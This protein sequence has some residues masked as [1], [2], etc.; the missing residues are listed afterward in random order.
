MSQPI[1]WT[2]S[3]L[4]VGMSQIK[5]R[6]NSQAAI[7]SPSLSEESAS[8]LDARRNEPISW[9]AGGIEVSLVF[10][11]YNPFCTSPC[12]QGY[13]LRIAERC[14]LAHAVLYSRAALPKLIALN[15][16]GALKRV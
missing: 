2:T 11:I 14:Y 4:P 5:A 7:E 13:T 3:L 10:S 8:H 9:L 15:E 16:Q 6:G 1:T 12:F